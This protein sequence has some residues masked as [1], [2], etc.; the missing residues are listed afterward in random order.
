MNRNLIELKDITDERGSLIAIEN[1]KNI[2][3]EIKRVYYL[4]NLENDKPRGF[5]AHKSLKQLIICISGECDFILNN[6]V[7]EQTFHLN[8]PTQA[9]L[10]ESLV[11]R[12]MINFSSN[13]ILLVLASDFYNEDDYIRD[14]NVFLDMVKG[15]SND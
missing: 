7:S 2:P 12:E 11:W 15:E 4:F 10:C 8:S 14:Y 9:I 13:A 5:H 6:G 3:F 1:L